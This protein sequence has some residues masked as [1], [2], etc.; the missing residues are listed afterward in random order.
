MP[1]IYLHFN[2]LFQKHFDCTVT[3]DFDFG[4]LL[5]AE[6]RTF[7]RTETKSVMYTRKPLHTP[8][9]SALRIGSGSPQ[10]ANMF[11]TE[12]VNHFRFTLSSTIS[13]TRRNA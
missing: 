1:I 3:F 12:K 6:F 4:T 10:R 13:E 8:S 9:L 11:P 7:K 2:L 5:T